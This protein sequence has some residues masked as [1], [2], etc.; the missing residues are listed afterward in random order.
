VSVGLSVIHVV[1]DAHGAQAP[2]IDSAPL[3]KG[4][5]SAPQRHCSNAPLE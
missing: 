5:S 1:Q 4:P 2:H 3:E